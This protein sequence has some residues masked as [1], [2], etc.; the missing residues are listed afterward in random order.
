PASPTAVDVGRRVRAGE[1]RADVKA[2]LEMLG[3]A[4]GFQPLLDVSE[5]EARQQLA[6]A[7]AAA[8]S[9]AAQSARGQLPAV[10]DSEVPEDAPAAEQF[11]LRWR[12]EAA[13]EQVQALDAYWVSAAEHGMNAS[14]FTARVI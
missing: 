2:A 10:P 1:V 5:E 9:Y 13:A 8:L 7:S 12:G 14:T 11:L 4:R 6:L 3:P